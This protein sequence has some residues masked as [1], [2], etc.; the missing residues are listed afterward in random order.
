MSRGRYLFVSD[1]HLDAD[2]PEAVAQFIGFLRGEALEADAL[3]I[4]G[5]LF[6]NWIGDDDDEPTRAAICAALREYT[7]RIPCHVM[8]GNRD[9]LLG[10][11]F[12]RRSGCRLLPDPVRVQL[13]ATT[14]LLSHGDLLCTA[15]A[16]Y[17]RFRDFTRRPATQRRFLSLP[18]ST[19]RALARAARAGSR[20][21]TRNQPERIMD[22]SPQAVTALFRLGATG[23]LV[24]GH[25]HR[26]A[27]HAHEVD[28]RSATRIV[29]GD[30]YEQGSCLAL[31]ADGRYEMLPVA[32]RAG[33]T[34]SIE[35]SS[36]RV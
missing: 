18:L 13:G 6:E 17:Q 8:L 29:L 10:A 34:L 3:Y 21:Y 33:S 31:H 32:P 27:T 20:R 30:W 16:G 5:D 35:P 15:D 2:S 26:P 22:V 12:E 1:L 25:T 28:G 7:A 24:H 11:G 23:L 19:R 4:L 14:L 9:F 36:S